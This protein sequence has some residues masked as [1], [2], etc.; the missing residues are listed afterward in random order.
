MAHVITTTELLALYQK[1]NW[2]IIDVS[3]HKDAKVHYENEHLLG[4]L[5]VDLNT[6][7]ADIK[8][9]T[10]DGGRH[11]LPSISEF[12]KTLSQLGI[13]SNTHV[14]VYDDKN[15]ANAS[16]RFW[17]MLKAIGH[18]KVQI[19]DGGFQTAKK[20]NFPTTS[21]TTEIKPINSVY[22]HST[23]LL[24]IVTLEEVENA[25]NDSSFKII[26]V[27]DEERYKGIT[28]PL[29]KMAGHI[30]SAINIPFSNNLTSEGNFRAS[31]EL[32]LLYKN[33]FEQTDTNKIIIH[34]GSGV[35]ACHTLLAMAH[36]G[37]EIPNLYVGSW[38]EWSQ[39]DK[40][41]VTEN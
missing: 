35:T 36:A 4:A 16:A 28:E 29:D 20:L 39:N 1:E 14:V 6:Q 40:P 37:F 7:L 34:C 5:F 15:G 21:K 30:P 8:P 32:H 23:W 33:I 24:P 26:D 11:P 10:A 19:L 27:R 38:S 22:P 13:Q 12:A 2:V 31:E 18:E 17:W 9:N 3:N 25:I 41:I